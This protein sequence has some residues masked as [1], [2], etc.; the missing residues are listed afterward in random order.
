[1]GASLNSGNSRSGRGRRNGY[2]QMSEIN[3]TPMVDV[4]LVLLII[5]MVAAP[6]LTAGVEVDLPESE[7]GAINAQVEPLEVFVT[8]SGKVMFQES[9][10]AIDELAPKI[11]AI[12]ASKPDLPV[13]VKGDKDIDYGRIMQVMG[14]LNAG[15]ITKVAL[16]TDPNFN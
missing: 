15:G 5:F 1:M 11:G 9:E 4:M 14:K 7:A 10:V 12:L 3:V 8:K 2:T 13:Y 16:V 6:L